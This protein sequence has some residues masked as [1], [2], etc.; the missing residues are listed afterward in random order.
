MTTPASPRIRQ[1][2]LRLPLLQILAAHP[3]GLPASAAVSAVASALEL[4][5]AQVHERVALPGGG[6]VNAFAR[7]VRWVRQQGKDAGQLDGSIRNL[8]RITPRG[9]HDL[10]NALPGLVITV[11]ETRAGRALWA[12]AEAAFATLKDDSVNLWITSPP[13]PLQ[14][15]KTYG[16]FRGDEYLEWLTAISRELHRTLTPDGSLFLNLGDTWE[17]G[18]P[19]LSLYQER[20]LLAL[21]DQLGFRLAQRLVWHNPSRLPGPAE[22]VTVRRCRLTT[23]TEQLYWLSKNDHPKAN[24]AEVLRPYSE[25]M[26]RRQQRGGETGATRP[27][28]H[29]LQAGAFAEDRGGSIPHNLITAAHTSS[30]TAYLRYCRENDLPVHPARFPE[31]LAELPIRMCTNEGDLVGDPFAGSCTTAAVAERLN[32]RW[33][34]IE[35]SFSYLQGAVSRFEHATLLDTR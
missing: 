20:L 15:E 12:D 10:R 33:L 7:D 14:R 24:N 18:R 8:W 9:R 34:A 31:A 1:N 19:T 22:W 35:R 2:Q 13:Y 4:D 3:E 16:N 25:S 26:R 21:C 27:S 23:A 30:N 6:D 5:S 29:D 28:G 32:R 17:R 11:F